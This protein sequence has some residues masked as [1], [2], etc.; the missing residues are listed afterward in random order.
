MSRRTLPGKL[1]KAE[2]ETFVEDMAREAR[3][4]DNALPEGTDYTDEEMKV[5][6]DRVR[7]VRPCLIRTALTQPTAEAWSWQYAPGI[8]RP[9]LH[10]IFRQVSAGTR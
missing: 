8:Y 1:P 4:P 6:Q 9:L 7:R 5:I 10:H 2:A 3:L